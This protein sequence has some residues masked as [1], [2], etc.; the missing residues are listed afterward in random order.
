MS[1][2]PSSP[3][4]PH[5]FHH[6]QA[7]L[8]PLYDTPPLPITQPHRCDSCA[9]CCNNLYL[10]AARRFEAAK[11]VACL[12]ELRRWPHA[13]LWFLL[14]LSPTGDS[15]AFPDASEAGRSMTRWLRPPEL[16]LQAPLPLSDRG[17]PPGCLPAPADGGPPDTP[18]P[19]SAAVQRC[20]L[21]RGT[22]PSRGL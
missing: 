8:F 22:G 17:R 7:S 3:K 6:G 15:A 20:S 1:Y 11:S 2:I 19:F 9:T 13:F 14:Y 16:E 12:P 4:I 10:F 18:P 5:P 21:N